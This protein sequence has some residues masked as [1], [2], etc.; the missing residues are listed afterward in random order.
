ME[1]LRGTHDR[2]V[3]QLWD[4][5]AN[6]Y[7]GHGG[8]VRVVRVHGSRCLQSE[9]GASVWNERQPDVQREL[10]VGCVYGVRRSDDASVWQL[11]DAIAHVSGRR[12]V[13]QLVDVLGRRGLRT[14]QLARLR[15]VRD[16]DAD[17]QRELWMGP[18]Q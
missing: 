12:S 10:P 2:I 4:A 5:F 6:V 7:R 1:S 18:V 15:S 8:L 9:R 3:W 14:G 16:R 13:V 17:V 11:R